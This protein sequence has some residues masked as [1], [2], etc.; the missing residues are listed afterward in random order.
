MEKISIAIPYHGDRVRWTM[1]TI[2]NCH[3]LPFIHEIVISVDK[4]SPEDVKKIQTAT[5]AYKKVKIFVSDTKLF[6]L[7]NKMKAVSLCNTDWVAL[8]D[9]DNVVSGQYFGSWLKEPHIKDMIYCPERGISVLDYSDFVNVT[10][11]LGVIAY[12]FATRSKDVTDNLSM[13]LN[14]GNYILHRETWLR[15]LQTEENHDPAAADVYYANYHCLLSGMVLRVVKGMTYHHTVH[16]GST[17][18]QTAKESETE[19]NRLK[20]LIEGDNEN[21]GDIQACKQNNLSA[22]H[23]WS[24]TGGKGTILLQSEKTGDRPGTLVD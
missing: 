5:K 8:I 22:A 1:Q 4:S 9:S 3:R 2:N 13:L 18:L 23:N 16:R 19:V 21:S 12:N 24:S 6:V 14:T 7:K 20:K 17:Y 11:G 15:S 10:L